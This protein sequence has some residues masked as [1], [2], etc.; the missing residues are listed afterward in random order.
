MEKKNTVII[1]IS[2]AVQTADLN[3]KLSQ[4]FPILPTSPPRL[5][6]TTFSSHAYSAIADYSSATILVPDSE[7]ALFFLF[8]KE[9]L[10]LYYSPLCPG[11]W[12]AEPSFPT[13]GPGWR[14][15]P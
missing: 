1:S 8:C 15:F 11:L 9:L 7:F 3:E 4:R 10:L 12:Q 14:V 5:P 6:V 13:L 2:V